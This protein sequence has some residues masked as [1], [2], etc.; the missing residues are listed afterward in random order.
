[1]RLRPNSTCNFLEDAESKKYDGYS[2]VDRSEQVRTPAAFGSLLT[3][4][5]RRPKS[6]RFPWASVFM[7]DESAISRPRF[8][9]TV[10]CFNLIFGGVL[11]LCGG[12][13][14]SI[15][16]PFLV[17]NSPFRLDPEETRNLIGEMRRQ[18]IEDAKRDE[19]SAVDPTVKER[20]RVTRERLRATPEPLAEKLDFEKINAGLPWLSSYLWADLISGPILNF[21]LV[22]SGIGLAFGNGKGKTL[23]VSVLW[24]KIARLAALSVFL[25]LIVVPGV[26]EAI[27]ELAGTEFF[28]NLLHQ[29][30]EVFNSRSGL[31]FNI[32][33]G[34][35]VQIVSALGYIYAVMSLALGAIYPVVGLILLSRSGKPS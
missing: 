19:R 25:G 26:V 35:F 14:L 5:S 15:F 32:E 8:F 16:V 4:G 20:V 6:N 2:R 33:P 17:E 9:R 28:K 27:S 13:G 7:S 21:C 12:L 18:A 30:F 34:E 29:A 11:I 24:L 3:V 22:I 10:G 23:A 31:S 1:M